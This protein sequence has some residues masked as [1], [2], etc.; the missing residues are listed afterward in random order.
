YGLVNRAAHQCGTADQQPCHL[1]PRK[2]GRRSHVPGELLERVRHDDGTDR[3]GR[4]VR[5]QLV[6]RVQHLTEVL[7]STAFSN[8]TLISS[9]N[10]HQD[11]ADYPDAAQ[12]MRLEAAGALA[13][14]PT[15][16]AVA[17]EL[18]FS[19]HAGNRLRACSRGR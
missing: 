9:I 8:I 17:F 7:L 5:K 18:T 6:P 1:Q 3:K 14:M 2:A 16:P 19:E 4:I 11:A 12:S 13:P 15:M 10:G